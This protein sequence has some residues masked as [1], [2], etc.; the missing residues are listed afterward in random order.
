MADQHRWFKLWHSALSDDELQALTPALR[1]AWAAL[2]CHTK[3][4][5]TRGK[6]VITRANAVLACAMGVPLPDLIAV[7]QTLPHVHIEEGSFDNG[8]V[9][10]TWKN[11]SKYQEDSTVAQRVASLR[12]KRREEEKREEKSTTSMSGVRQTARRCLEF[13]N[14]KTG[15][16]YQPVPANLSLL[17][18]RIREGATERNIRGVIA[19]KCQEW[20]G[21]AK[22]AQFLRPK[23]LFNA[24]N[25]AQYLGQREAEHADLSAVSRL[26]EA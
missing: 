18:A 26:P 16:T 17:E 10:V 13:L 4:H 12:S 2:G 9:T 3:V 21:D 14:Q 7:I 15:R 24:T 6:V 23:T 22:M 11:W 5:G 25:F 20:Q 8:H 19:R 1:W